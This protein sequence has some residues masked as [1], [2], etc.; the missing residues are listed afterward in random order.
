MNIA[1]KAEMDS[2]IKILKNNLDYKE[3][4]FHVFDTFL[5]LMPVKSES[6]KISLQH[7]I[8]TIQESH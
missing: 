4:K 2:F 3:K 1:I 7:N 6:L 8:F 5:R